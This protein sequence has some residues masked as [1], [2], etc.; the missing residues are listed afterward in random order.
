MTEFNE[1]VLVYLI[2]Y[3]SIGLKW[4]LS[5]NIP[6]LK[7]CYDKRIQCKEKKM[8]KWLKKKREWSILVPFKFLLGFLGVE[9]GDHC[10]LPT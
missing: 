6:Y 2:H 9:G 10:G 1:F 5:K 8:N 4:P 3:V 7:T